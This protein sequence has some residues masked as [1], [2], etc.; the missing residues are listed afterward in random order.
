MNKVICAFGDSI[1]WGRGL[2][3]RTGWVNL[4][5][6]Y[7]EI[8]SKFTVNLY[9]LGIDGDTSEDVIRRFDAEAAA[10]KPDTI[11]IAI[12]V[13]DSGYRKTKA[14]PLVLRDIFERNLNALIGKARRF[15]KDIIFVG[16]A[17]GSDRETVPLKAS[18]TGKCYDKKNVKIYNEMIKKVCTKE[19]ILFIGVLDKLIDSDFYDGLHPNTVGHEKIFEEVKKKLKL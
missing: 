14:H 19:K 6:N 18:T 9:D 13:N 12:G 2:P 5:R 1:L 4:L 7:A 8:K 11:I 15:T 3:L 16:I 10:R 17:K